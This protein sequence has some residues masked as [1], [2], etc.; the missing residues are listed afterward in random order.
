MFASVPWERSP[1]ESWSMEPLLSGSLLLC[2]GAVTLR[3]STHPAGWAP[4]RLLSVLLSPLQC[5]CPWEVSLG[6]QRA[7]ATPPLCPC[8]PSSCIRASLCPVLGFAL[9]PWAEDNGDILLLQEATCPRHPNRPGATCW[10]AT[11]CTCS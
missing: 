2:L 1:G 3:C 4:S 6:L 5:H 7:A 10:E 11:A 9:L 8:F